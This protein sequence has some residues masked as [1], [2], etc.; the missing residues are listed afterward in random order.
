MNS[1]D[2]DDFKPDYSLEVAHVT[3][4]TTFE[5]ILI[6]VMGMDDFQKQLE[7]RNDN[8]PDQAHTEEMSMFVRVLVVRTAV[9]SSHNQWLQK[10]FHLIC[11]DDHNALI[12][13]KV[14]LK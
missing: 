12:K 9:I 6:P 1:V 8:H 5:D 2:Y 14:K 10:S 7:E 3:C 13:T 4:V 11:I